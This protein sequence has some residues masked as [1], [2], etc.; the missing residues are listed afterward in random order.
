MREGCEQNSVALGKEG[1]DGPAST[2]PDRGVR[3]IGW[4]GPRPAPLILAL[5]KAGTGVPLNL[6]DKPRYFYEYEYGVRSGGLD[7]TYQSKVV[8]PGGLGFTGTE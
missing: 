8:Q 4:W 1:K 6:M 3:R 2:H 5:K 7:I